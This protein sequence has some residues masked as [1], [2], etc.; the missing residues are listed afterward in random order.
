MIER[1]ER[2]LK[3]NAYY[4]IFLEK[5]KSRTENRDY[6][7]L[8]NRFLDELPKKGHILDIGCGTGE[9]LKHFNSLGFK[10]IGIEPSYKSREYCLKQNLEVI[11]GSFETL[12]E[13]IKEHN[14]R[15]TGVWCAAS[16]LHVP[17]EDF[18]EVVGDIYDILGEGG[19]FFFTVRLGNGSKWD[20]YDDEKDNAERL[21]QLYDEPFLEHTLS[22]IGFETT[23]KLIED[24]YWGRPTKWISMILKK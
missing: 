15:V 3:N 10:T 16:I 2:L 22:H 13:N 9:H 14:V 17:L 24:S 8:F 5:V 12:K 21:I 1:Q 19:K 18:K 23:L 6:T 7:Y 20:K 4:D 11:D